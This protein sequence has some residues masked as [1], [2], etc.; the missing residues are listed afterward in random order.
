MIQESLSAWLEH[1]NRSVALVFTDVVDS[2]NLLY[3]VTTVDYRRIIRA[4]RSRTLLLLKGRNARLVDETGDQIFAAFGNVSDA[5]QFAR[6]LVADPGHPKLS[7]RAGI[8]YG[9]VSA[10]ENAL[11]GRSVHLAVRVMQHGG[12]GELWASDA[13]KRALDSQLEDLSDGVEVISDAWVNL[14]G[15]PD[16]QL[17][18]RLC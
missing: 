1:N 15:V 7:I 9:S 10:E 5:Q 4:H 16:E 13:A 14:K 6:D 12:A 8:H 17:L 2:T 11:V 3:S 18:W